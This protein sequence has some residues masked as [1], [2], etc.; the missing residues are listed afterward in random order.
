[1]EQALKYLK[2]TMVIDE[3]MADQLPNLQNMSDYIESLNHLGTLYQE[4]NAEDDALN[5]FTKAIHFGEKMLQ[6]KHR[7]QMLLNL[8]SS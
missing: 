3:A 8:N 5:L 6:K 1:M 4:M 7:L 2:Y